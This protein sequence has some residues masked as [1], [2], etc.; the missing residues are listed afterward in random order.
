MNLE[1]METALKRYGF[2]SSD[3]LKTWLNAAMHEIEADHDWS[4]LEGKIE[5]VAATPNTAPISIPGQAGK[6]IAVRDTT[7]NRKLVFYD[8]W[9][10]FREI[11]EPEQKGQPVLYT[12]QQGFL[13]IN[14]WPLPEAAY[15]YAILI[16]L[17]TKDMV[18]VG[19]VPKTGSVTGEWPLAMHYA[20]VLK[21]AVIALFA[22][23]EEER[24]E[25]LQKQFDQL[26]ERLRRKYGDRTLDEP[27]SVVDVMGYGPSASAYNGE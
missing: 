1:E 6:V 16:Q 23:N 7:N 25:K 14:L 12:L 10:F 3:P 17:L 4:F 9:R 8:Y 5:N 11:E 13:F 26:M 20:I 24:G 19:D 22:E 27:D 2:D 15:K 21:A 18:A